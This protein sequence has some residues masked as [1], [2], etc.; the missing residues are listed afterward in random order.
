MIKYKA[1]LSLVYLTFMSSCSQ[2]V[3]ESKKQAQKQTN[4]A[5]DTCGSLQITNGR[6]TK[7]EKY[8]AVAHLTIYDAN[9]KK[10][11]CTGTFIR[12]DL[13]LTAAHCFAGGNPSKVEITHTGG[14]TLGSNVKINE[15]FFTKTPDTEGPYDLAVIKVSAAQ[16]INSIP[17]CGF[18]PAIKDDGIILGYG[19]TANKGDFT[20]GDLR[21]GFTEIA[22]LSNGV[23]QTYGSLTTTSGDGSFASTA[24]GDSG[25]PFLMT[26]NEGGLCIMALT[27]AGFE[28]S[29]A[30]GGVDNAHFTYLR[31]SIALDFFTKAGIQFNEKRSFTQ[32][33]DTC[34]P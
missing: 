15:L 19:R 26:D 1:L 8:N 21:E 6:K 23:L 10:A 28:I 12:Q 22:K 18:E 31:S 34:T 32:S 27:H 20:Y 11:F 24:Y 9:E 29:H 5:A 2:E 4:A 16:N 13:V 25:G 30:S 17:V 3:T 33:T 7:D 14:S